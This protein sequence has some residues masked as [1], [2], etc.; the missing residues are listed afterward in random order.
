MNIHYTPSRHRQHCKTHWHT[1]I[2]RH[3]SR[4]INTC[5]ICM[6]QWKDRTTV[7]QCLYKGRALLVIDGCVYMYIYGHVW[8]YVYRVGY[9]MWLLISIVTITMYFYLITC[10]FPRSVSVIVYMYIVYSLH[11]QHLQ[12]IV[13][14]SLSM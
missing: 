4:T 8:Y 3:E 1:K 2:M 5:Y 11:I 9:L 13:H 12:E 6:F 7:W 10:R 14:C